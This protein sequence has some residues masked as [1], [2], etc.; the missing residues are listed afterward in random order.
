[1]CDNIRRHTLLEMTWYDLEK[2]IEKR[3]NKLGG[4]LM[5]LN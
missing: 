3:I 2:R 1:M 4:L 5:D